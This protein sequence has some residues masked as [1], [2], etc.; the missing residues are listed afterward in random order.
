M[1]VDYVCDMRCLRCFF[2]HFSVIKSREKVA[3]LECLMENKERRDRNI[4]LSVIKT[5]KFLRIL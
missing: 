2:E 4:V 5:S 3:N 1:L